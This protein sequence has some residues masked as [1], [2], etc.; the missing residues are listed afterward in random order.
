MPSA[1]AR[2]KYVPAGRFRSSI[3]VLQFSPS[4]NVVVS[5]T[6][7]PFMSTTT[8][9]TWPVMPMMPTEVFSVAGLGNNSNVGF[10]ELACK[11]IPLASVRND[12]GWLHTLMVF[13]LHFALM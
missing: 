7:R 3:E 13:S 11:L 8:S 1:V 4:Q 12:T 5:L 2:T 9:A 6:M 10:C